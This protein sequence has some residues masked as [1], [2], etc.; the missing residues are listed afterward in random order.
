MT[1]QSTNQIYASFM[2]Q[3]QL[4]KLGKLATFVCQKEFR[5]T[6]NVTV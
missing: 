2:G 5:K 4:G 6:P 3:G 1:Q